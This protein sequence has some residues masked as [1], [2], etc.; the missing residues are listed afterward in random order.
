[1]AFNRFIK[2]I[3]NGREIEVYGDGSQKRD[4][5]YVEDV[6][7]ATL[8]AIDAKAGSVYNVGSGKSH[9]LNEAISIISKLLG[10]KAGVRHSRPAFGDVV[11]TSADISKIGRELGYEPTVNLEEGLRKQVSWQVGLATKSSSS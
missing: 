11:A 10:R 4:Y 6:A 5:T 3:S 2:L 7:K 1:M 8:L 9:S